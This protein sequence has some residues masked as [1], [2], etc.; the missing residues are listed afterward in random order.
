MPDFRHILF[1]TDFSEQGN[2]FRPLVQFMAREFQARLTLLHVVPILRTADYGDIAGMFP[3]ITD[4]APIEERM[5]AL[6]EDFFPRQ[7]AEGIDIHREVA[8]GDPAVT[9]A[10]YAANHKADLIMLPTH[11]YGRFRSLLMGSVVSKVLHDAGCPVLTAAHADRA[12]ENGSVSIRN[13]LAAVDTIEE[14]QDV[15]RGSAELGQKFQATVKLVHAVPAAEHV[16]GDTGGD[17]FGH[18]LIHSARDFIQNLQ[19][20]TGTNFEVL[21]EAGGVAQTIHRAALDTKADLVVVGRGVMQAPFG[22]LRSREYEI[23][24]ESPCPVLSL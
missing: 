3:A 2:A 14:Q 16:V 11:G 22:R 10:D 6:L 19:A 4:F 17:E 24:R 5:A 8:I 23:I 21:V 12:E 20:S 7:D 13:I 15:I 1:P 18:F 9:I